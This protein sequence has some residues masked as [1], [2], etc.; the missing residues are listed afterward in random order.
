MVFRSNAETV[1]QL[2]GVSQCVGASGGEAVIGGGT[3]CLG[4]ESDNVFKRN[5]L[6]MAFGGIGVGAEGLGAEGHWDF[7]YTGVT[8]L[9]D[10]RSRCKADGPAGAPS[11]PSAVE[12]GDPT[13]VGMN[14]NGIPGF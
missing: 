7:G 1:D 4:V 13:G 10:Y 12:P 6:W 5:G 9:M 2:R 14:G 8:D 3:V 11:R